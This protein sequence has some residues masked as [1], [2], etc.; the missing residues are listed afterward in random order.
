MQYK[1]IPYGISNF[2]KIRRE[3]YAYVDKT[4]FIEMIENDPTEYAFLIRPRRFGKSLFLSVLTHYYD[5]RF[6]DDFETLFGDLYIGQ[7]PTSKH[8]S[9]FVLKFNFS[10]IDANSVERFEKSF[11][12]SVKSNVETFLSE[13]RDII[14]EYDNNLAYFRTL[15]TTKSIL[16]FAIRIA[17]NTGK[18]CYVIIDEYDHFA[19][20]LIEQG[21][22][23]GDKQYKKLIW[24]NSVVRDFYETLKT[25]TETVVDKILITGVTPIMLDDV[26]SGFNISNN[27][28]LDTRFNE[29]LGFTEK[30]AEWLIDVCGVNKDD[31]NKVD[32]KFLYDGYLFSEDGTQTLYNSAMLLYFLYHTRVSGGKVKKLIDENIKTDYSKIQ[33]LLDRIENVDKI[34][35]LLNTDSVP[36]NVVSQFSIDK[37]GSIENFLSLLYYMGLV[38]LAK[39]EDTG[40]SLLRIPNLSIKTMYWEYKRLSTL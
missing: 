30:E 29:I 23:S 33:N 11:V 27:I 37:I 21:T 2:E 16:E 15:T 28:S 12:D 36:S 25:A 19:N 40:A 1:Q 6:A 34:E 31:A 38:T 9:M 5:L 35:V 14:S 18:K 3:N 32:K 10:G 39:D 26:T 8:N 20:D 13:H 7:N 24:A 4:R 17:G 22:N